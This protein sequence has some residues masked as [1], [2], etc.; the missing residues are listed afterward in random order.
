MVRAVILCGTASFIMAFLGAVLAFS[1]VVPSS[2]SAQS[3][4]AQEVRASAFTLVGPDDTVVARLVRSPATGGA[5][6]I[7]YNAAGTR[8][9]EIAQ[10]SVNVYDED[11]TTLAFIA[12]RTF[13]PS[14]GGDP[15]VNGVVLGPG[16]SISTI[17][18]SP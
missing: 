14:P 13:A 15:P 12:G 6:L 16:G 18:P 8:R 4:E 5:L 17:V 10:G 11:G 9:M 7:L 2:A 1:L 3:G